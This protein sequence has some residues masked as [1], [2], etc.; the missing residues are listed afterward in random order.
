MTRKAML[1]ALAVASLAGLVVTAPALA[2]TRAVQ[3][4][5]IQTWGLSASRS[6]RVGSAV[7]AP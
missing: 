7:P 3:I 1:I 5:S 2:I 6:R 4:P